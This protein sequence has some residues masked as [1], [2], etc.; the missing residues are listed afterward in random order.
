MFLL[1]VM[2][3]LKLTMEMAGSWLYNSVNVLKAIALN[4]LNE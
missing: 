1:E 4:T 3:V 2:K